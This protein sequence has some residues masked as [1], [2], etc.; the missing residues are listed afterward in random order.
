MWNM[1]DTVSPMHRS[2][3]S[4]YISRV[5]HPGRIEVRTLIYTTV[6][7][8]GAYI[9]IDWDEN[10]ID[11]WVADSRLTDSRGNT[12]Q[13]LN[14]CTPHSMYDWARRRVKVVH[15]PDGS[16]NKLIYLPYYPRH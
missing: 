9:A 4:V 11:G 14:I 13:W 12:I 3:Y 16:I 2:D 6:G 8:N 7:D 1:C 5:H 10:R 15:G